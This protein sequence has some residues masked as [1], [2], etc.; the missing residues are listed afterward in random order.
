MVLNCFSFL[1]SPAWTRWDWPHINCSR[2]TSAV[3][4]Q[5]QAL[6][7]AV[8]SERTQ[9]FI[10]LLSVAHQDKAN[11]FIW[12]DLA[13]W[14]DGK[15]KISHWL[16][17]WN[18]F[19]RQTSPG[20]SSLLLI[21]WDG[22]TPWLEST[23]GIINWLDIVLTGTHLFYKTSQLATHIRD[24]P[25]SCQR[26]DRLHQSKF[27]MLPEWKKLWATRTLTIGWPAKLSSLQRSALMRWLGTWWSIWLSSENNL[28]HRV[29]H[30]ELW[31]D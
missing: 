13:K 10:N 30:P 29:A 9:C 1:N 20:D 27:T 2:S 24:K 11:I 17:C 8:H 12:K 18:H 22:L 21:R 31:F 23:C 3:N 4:P 5:Q 6:T 7:H 16:K 19:L 14:W 25:V 28:C 15:T 26:S